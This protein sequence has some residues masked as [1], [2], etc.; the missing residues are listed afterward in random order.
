[1][2][3]LLPLSI[4]GF[5]IPPIPPSQS[6][7]FHLLY[8][9]R[10]FIITFLRLFIFLILLLESCLLLF[11]HHLPPQNLNFSSSPQILILLFLTLFL[12]ILFTPSLLLNHFSLKT[13]FFL[14]PFFSLLNL[15]FLPPLLFTI[16][17][18]L[19]SLPLIILFLFFVFL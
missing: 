17:I 19:I 16:F 9:H 15:F 11:S 7:L 3:F 14:P 5:L 13:I 12:L 1:M 4:L 18:Y 2:F 8:N 6:P 10:L